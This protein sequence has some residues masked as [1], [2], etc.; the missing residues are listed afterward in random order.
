ME[1]TRFIGLAESVLYFSS[2]SPTVQQTPLKL[3]SISPSYLAYPGKKNPRRLIG[4]VYQVS[5]FFE[6]MFEFYRFSRAE[7]LWVT[8]P[9]IVQFGSD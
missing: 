2:P 9:E 5:D 4:A 1:I 6:L 7:L 3:C 8:V